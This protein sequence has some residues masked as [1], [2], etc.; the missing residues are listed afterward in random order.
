MFGVESLGRRFG[1]RWIFRGLNFE[2][3]AGDVLVVLGRNGSGKSTLLKVLA[4]LLSPT[5]GN[6]LRPNGEMRRTL[7]YAA[8]DLAVYPSLTAAEHLELAGKLR[9][10]NPRTYDLLHEVG[11]EDAAHQPVI[12]FSSG[13]RAR[14]KFAL[15]IQAQPSI[16]LL[17]EPS[18]SLDDAGK[19]LLGKIVEQQR[20]RGATI[21]ATND[22]HDH[23]FATHTLEL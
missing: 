4:G 21:L 18:A 9:N 17:D 12:Q 22:V 16:L 23:Q 10:V 14:L 20:V 15:S 1:A 13:M 3:A 19:E 5:E 11:L 7:G 2:M 6:I 8:L